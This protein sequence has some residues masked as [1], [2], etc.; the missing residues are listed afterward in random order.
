MLKRFDKTESIFIILVLLV[1]IVFIIMIT[2]NQLTLNHRT[3]A[4]EIVSDR[5]E[6]MIADNKDWHKAYDVYDSYGEYGEQL[7]DFSKWKF[8]SYYPG[9]NKKLKGQ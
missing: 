6:E 2:K 1:F 5:A 4:L 7:Y 8:D 3:D 9:L